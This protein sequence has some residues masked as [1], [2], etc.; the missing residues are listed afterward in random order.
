MPEGWPPQACD[1]QALW[2]RAHSSS[3]TKSSSK[4]VSVDTVS[5]EMAITSLYSRQNTF[6]LILGTL[7]SNP[8]TLAI[9]PCSR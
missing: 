1:V 4:Q 5:L 8:P 2:V 9:A 7:P 3:S 6:S